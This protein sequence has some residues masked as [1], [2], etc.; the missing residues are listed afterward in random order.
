MNAKITEIKMR[1]AASVNKLLCKKLGEPLQKT[2]KKR[3]KRNRNSL[4]VKYGNI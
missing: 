2:K 3:K 4:Q 1:V